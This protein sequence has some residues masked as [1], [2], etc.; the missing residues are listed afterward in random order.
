LQNLDYD[1]WARIAQTAG[2]DTDV[3]VRQ[4]L[5]SLRE[6]AKQ[7]FAPQMGKALQKYVQENNGQL[8]A[9]VLQ[10]KPYFESPASGDDA[11]LARYQMIRT[12]NVADLQP[13]EMILAEKAAVDDEYDNLIQI[14]LNSWKSQSVGKY[15]GNTAYGRWSSGASQTQAVG[16]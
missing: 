8:P 7:Y 4:A 13:D 9:D 2:L 5:S 12:G 16:K 3:G 10:L 1:T 14:S 6:I 15:T 11:T